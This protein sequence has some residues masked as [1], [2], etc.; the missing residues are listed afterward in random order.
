MSRT[1][2]GKEGRTGIERLT[3]NSVDISEWLDFEFYDIVWYWDGPNNTDEN[4]K[5]GRWLGIAH[6]IGSNMCYWILNDKGNSLAR[7]TVQHVTILEQQN[8]DIRNKI[9]AFTNKLHQQLDDTNFIDESDHLLPFLQDIDISADE[10]EQDNA[11]DLD[12]YTNNAYDKFISAQIIREYNG[13]K[14]QGQ[15][16]KRSQNDMGVPIGTK[17]EIPLFDTRQYEVRMQDGTMA[18]YTANLIAESLDAKIDPEGNVHRIFVEIIDHQSND[19]AVKRDHYDGTTPTTKGWQLLV[20]WRDGTTSWLPLRELKASDP[21]QVAEYA[22]AN[23]IIEEPAF[24]WWA[25]DVLHKRN[26]MISKLKSQY[27][28]TTHKFGVQLPHSVAEALQIDT[29]CNNS[30]WEERYRKGYTKR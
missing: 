22:Y 5:L 1:A 3:G 25:G 23:N 17:N 4:P 18:E 16:I 29:V 10:L 30:L 20:E 12:D 14:M 24:I 26:V 13:Q 2:R 6:H 7:T 27:W 11:V 21:V 15:V 19:K 9:E 28:R 8:N